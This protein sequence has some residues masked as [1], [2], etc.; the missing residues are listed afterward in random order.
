M[1]QAYLV[2]VLLSAVVG[3]GVAF[4]A[5]LSRDKP[6]ARP[7]A[8]LLVAASFWAVAEGLRVALA[9]G[10]FWLLVGFVLSAF[11]PLAWLITV[12]EYTGL[13][14]WLVPRRAAALLAEPILYAALV[15]T[16]GAHELVAS[17]GAAPTG[18]GLS[19]ASTAQTGGVSTTPV[20]AEAAAGFDPGVAFWLH[21]AYSLLLLA[22]GA[23]LLVGLVLRAERVYSIQSAAMLVGV[24]AAVAVDILSAAG[25]LPAGFD[26]SGPGY[27]FAGVVVAAAMFRR[28]LFSLAPATRELGREAAITDLGDPIVTVDGEDRVVDVNGAAETALE[29]DQADC[30]DEQLAAVSPALAGEVRDGGGDDGELRMERDGE[31]RYYDVGVSELY[32]GYGAFT[33]RLITLRDV[34]ER[35][36]REQRLDVFNRLLRHNLRNELN[37]VRG[38]IQLAA[39]T[40]DDPET[41]THL[42][43]A[44]GTVDAIL[45][46]SDKIGS[47][48]RTLE[49]DAEGPVDLA[50]LLGA[51]DDVARPAVTI[52]LPDRL[53][54]A[55]G[56]SVSVAFAELVDNAI[57][58]GDDDPSVRIAVDDS[59]SDAEWVT[60]AV[61]DDGPGIAAR[62]WQVVVEGE[63]T[64]LRHASGVGLWL[65]S[66]TVE[67]FGG[68]LDVENTEQG[69]TVRVRLPRAPDEAERD[70]TTPADAGDA[71][72]AHGSGPE[73]TDGE[74]PA[75]S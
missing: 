20:A 70:D 63:E 69:C 2:A 32:R 51:D 10:G 36:R 22:A 62:E 35:R 5:W 71:R 65:V 67:R 55:A 50:R 24:A 16:N 8:F 53:P 14:E 58:H 68:S 74:S 46:R 12:L 37:V 42:E 66:W 28:D 34:T 75:R 17:R 39:E 49:S 26:P 23:A 4:L 6:G 13:E 40:S 43:D 61:S 29:T 47:L 1:S 54:V 44:A 27:V 41:A 18:S 15:W 21:Q 57:Q 60:V 48:S 7:L 73:T 9:D 25:L 56:P 59:R 72:E 11:V 3:M 64:P 38:K 31:V 52:D 33:G 19:G 30:L 45:A